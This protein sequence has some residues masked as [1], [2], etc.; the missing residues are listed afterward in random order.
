M[1]DRPEP[2]AMAPSAPEGDDKQSQIL[3]GAALVFAEDG[4]EGASMTRIAAAA[5]VSKGTVYNYF[6]GKRELFAAFMQREGTDR[7]VVLFDEVT[8]GTPAGPILTRICRRILEVLLSD[9]GLLVHRMAVAEAGKFPEL[10]EVFWS[11][12][13]QRAIACLAEAVERLAADGQLQVA[14]CHMA[15]EHLF[16]VL[17]TSLVLQRRLRLKAAVRPSEI[18]AVAQ[19]AV[20]FFLRAYGARGAG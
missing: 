9:A 20:S 11:V 3:R 8:P 14:D 17:Q 10:A 15:A 16:G 18:E 12:G 4:Y 5:G 2:K 1:S 7:I 19:G 13:P 6:A